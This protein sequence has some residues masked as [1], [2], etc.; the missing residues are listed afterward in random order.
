MNFS[1]LIRN[2]YSVRKYQN[3]KVEEEKLNKILEAGRFAPTAANLQPVKVIAIT[4]EKG[5]LKI[6][7]AADIYGAPL[8]LIVCADNTK[9]WIRPF[10]NKQTTDIDAS[11]VTDHMMLQASSLG[12]GSV[13]I[14]YFNPDI[15]KYE[16]K[17]PNNLIP[18][19]ILAVGYADDTEVIPVKNRKPMNEFVEFESL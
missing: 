12:L 14:C 6:S 16:F 3:K 7:K 10:D 2:R 11:I 5:L 13:W 8:A 17:L 1:E 9:A 19:N 4:E 15:L 18:I